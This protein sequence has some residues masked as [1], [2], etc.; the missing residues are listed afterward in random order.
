MLLVM[1]LFQ[2]TLNIAPVVFSGSSETRKEFWQVINVTN[3]VPYDNIVD[4][5]ITVNS[6][7]G[8]Y[9]AASTNITTYF[10]GS[11][12]GYTSY[13]D[14]LNGTSS[15]QHHWGEMD[16]VVSNG[17]LTSITYDEIQHWGG[18]YFDSGGGVSYTTFMGNTYMADWN[19]TNPYNDPDIISQVYWKG[20]V[21]KIIDDMIVPNGTTMYVVF[22]I[23]ITR[24]GVFTFDITSTP[25]V[26]V[27]PLNF[28]VGGAATLLVPY[29]YEK[30]QD[31]VNAAGPNFTVVVFDGI[32][33]EQVVINKSLTIQGMGNNTIVRPSSAGK[34]T[35]VLDGYFWGGTKN[36]AGIIVANTAA[37]SVTL[38][39]L[40]I[41]GGGIT[42]KPTGAD[43]VAGVFYRETGGTID[44][45]TVTNMTL[46]ATGTAVRGYGIYLSAITNAV[47]VEVKGCTITNYDKNGIDAHGNKLS[48][49]IRHNTLTGRGP[50]PSGDEVQNGI[51]VMD[52]AA[53]TVSTNA[54]S[55]MSYTPETWWSA[56]I[57]FFDSGGSAV[58]NT[59]TEC[60]IGVLFQDGNGSAQG[61]I[62]NGGTV[63]L[64]G[65]WAQY[66]K[67]GA[68]TA[69][70]V[71]NTVSGV[72]DSSGYE[73]G[74]I[75]AQSWNV[76]ASITVTISNNQLTGGGS[77]N[78]DGI[79]IG[80]VPAGSPAG[81]ITV[82]VINNTISG[83]EYG[84]RL[85]SSVLVAGSRV[86]FNN[87]TGNQ[88][89]G[90]SN[91]CSG[92]L[93]ASYNWWGNETGPYHPTLNPS[94]LGN[95]VSGNVLFE[96]WLIKPYPPLT[97]ISVVHVTPKLV[98]L[99]FPA[100]GTLF[101]VN[102]TIANVSM[103]YA[104][105][106]VFKWNSSLITLTNPTTAHKIPT[107]WGTNYVSQFNYSL[108]AGNY[109]LFASARSPAPPF[110]GTTTVASLTFKSIYDP[111]Y[112]Q[113]VTC[114]L[115]LENVI[116]SDRNATS[117][118]RLVYSGNYSYISAKPKLLFTSKEYTAK[119]V[120]TEFDVYIN[121]TNVVNLNAFYFKLTFN[122]TLLKVPSTNTTYIEILLHGAKESRGL[123]DGYVVFNVSGISPVVNGSLRLA[124]VRFTVNGTIWN[125]QTRNASCTL[126]FTEHQLNGTSG[127]IEHEAINATY[128]YKPVPGDL[129]MDGLVDIIDLAA[130]AQGF[131]AYPTDPR[132]SMYY[133]ADL[134]LD[135]IIN[136]FD[137]VMVA[138]NYGRTEPEP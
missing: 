35:T 128:I 88:L 109:S 132:W 43:Y 66:T 74:A 57:M 51:L 95:N 32:Y 18:M 124:R 115:S 114:S 121:V 27:S 37:G 71:N 82:A 15:L 48:V 99:E 93:D 7:E 12:P 25:G 59:I 52:G 126:E 79:F 47:S 103:L 125:I 20:N 68:W 85:E 73:N 53:G 34:L 119:K 55:N 90:I 77:T 94:G 6:R 58:N 134:N 54:I 107:V 40:K 76:N 120:P 75:G 1:G 17:S 22:K 106:F 122:S 60:Q 110:N 45:V 44:T 3:N 136:I 112:P 118:R 14:W 24:Q 10:N 67:G 16:W 116:I 101:T 102:V 111:V 29:D 28:T 130:V 135:N 123:G 131:G 39:G 56:G 72:K 89:Y 100:A 42:S 2:I 62:V 87:I 23:V 80:D 97:P 83:W 61:N 36:V 70:F 5:N 133:F 11:W 113:N 138:R 33:D 78:A 19:L 63:G 46:G 8:V 117:I 49:N 26:T 92:I 30:I 65:L 21:I 108:T 96:P 105:Q 104:F 38:K 31:A 4:I 41:D 86:N 137:I 98:A 9:I 91:N 69:S 50:L 64:L 129:N 13:M 127:T 84:V 81:N